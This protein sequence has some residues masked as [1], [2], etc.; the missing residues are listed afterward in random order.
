MHAITLRPRQAGR[1]LRRLAV[2]LA[3]AFLAA[4]ALTATHANATN[5]VEFSKPHTS[6]SSAVTAWN[7]FASNLVAANLPPGPQTY[8]LAIAQIAVHDALNAIDPRY[9]P[10]EFVGSAPRAST[11]AAVA[12]AAHDTLVKLVPQATVSVDA[13][14][15]AA[16]GSVPDGVHKDAGIATG[17]AAAVAILARRGSDDLPA[18]ITKPY[19]PGPASPGVYQLTPP[20]NFVILAGWS[21]LAPFALNS[22]SQFR[23]PAPPSVHS[24]TYTK[25]YNEVKS[26]GS[27]SSTT[28]TAGQTETALF[29]YDAAV[30]EWNLAA[31]KGLADRSADEWRAARTLS[32]LNISLADAV[33]ATFDTKFHYNYWR[34]ITA[35][36]S[37]DSDRNPA[38]HGDRNWDSLCVTPPFPE[39]SSTHAATGAAASTALAL[40]LGDRHTFTVTNPSGASRTYKRFSAAAYEEGI[41]RIYCGIHFRTAMNMGF[42]TGGR[43][44]H[45]VDK[46]LLRVVDRA[47]DGAEGRATPTSA[48]RA[49]GDRRSARPVATL[50]AQPLVLQAQLEHGRF[51]TRER[52]SA[53]EQGAG[54]RI[55]GDRRR[56]HGRLPSP[57]ECGWKQS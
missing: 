28:R 26:L 34:P 13:E 23:S 39:Y 14:Y 22:A 54:R 42:V 43:I 41:S 40:E 16:L 21:E 47:Q 38:T 18:A 1:H 8:T 55:P 33:I 36:R 3:A 46:T 11:A 51:A 7:T 45:Y 52:R 57:S 2:A 27:H 49:R 31:Q 32:V 30:K 29:W 35:I 56:R 37:G 10:Y 20:L 5:G 50:H 48:A 12:A 17:Q 4:A 15:D 6:G 19:T 53:G 44:A 9:E 25:D 24:L